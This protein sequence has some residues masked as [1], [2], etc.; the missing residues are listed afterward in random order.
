[1]AKAKTE[2]SKPRKNKK[3]DKSMSLESIRENHF[4]AGLL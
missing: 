4:T 3:E 1:M 2:A